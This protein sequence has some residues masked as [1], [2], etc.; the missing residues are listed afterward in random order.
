MSFCSGCLNSWLFSGSYDQRV[1]VVQTLGLFNQRVGPLLE[2]E[3]WSDD[4]VFRRERLTLVDQ[5]LR[6]DRPDIFV[7]QGVMQKGGSPYESDMNILKAG[8]LSGYDSFTTGM[9]T[10]DDTLEEEGLSVA[11]SL[12]LQINRDAMSKIEHDWKISNDAFM[13]LT[14]VESE[15]QVISVFNVEFPSDPNSI[16]NWLMIV[17]KKI[18]AYFDQTKNCRDRLVIAGQIPLV[19]KSRPVWRDFLTALD[20]QE[21][22]PDRCELSSECFTKTNQ[23]SLYKIMEN[24]NEMG[25][26]DR[27]LVSANSHV[28][29]SYRAFDRPSKASEYASKY[30]LD[31]MYPGLK[32]GWLNRI[33]FHRCE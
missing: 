23:N 30:G 7:V 6:T 19:N 2:G 27:V 12:P 17:T 24:Q 4:W 18:N 16:R 10:Y 5:A 9:V 32:F 13:A 1:V 22:V 15:G 29:D 14:L 20:L 33:R 21:V 3:S 8:A 28:V 31:A 25:R 26:V 11:V